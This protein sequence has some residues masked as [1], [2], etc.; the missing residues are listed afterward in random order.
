MRRRFAL[1]AGICS[2]IRA[3]RTDETGSGV[4]GALDHEDA[5]GWRA[6]RESSLSLAPS[7]GI[8]PERCG[9]RE[10]SLGPKRAGYRLGD[11]RQ[12]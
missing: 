5:S 4:I 7:A 9:L 10:S 1:A 2:W 3:P 12:G 6:S 8:W 11:H